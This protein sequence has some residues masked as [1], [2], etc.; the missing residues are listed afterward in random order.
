[1]VLKTVD[2]GTAAFRDIA[3]G[4]GDMFLLP[5][6]VP[7]NPVRFADTVGLVL[8]LP[9]PP[10]ALDRLRWY[11]QQCGAQVHEASFRCTDLGSQI[12]HAVERFRQ[13]AEA[14]RCARCGA[15]CDVVP[16]PSRAP[17]RS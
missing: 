1:M 11:C 4:E 8:E 17:D 14:R 3:I 6:G 10:G 5:A 13:D 16:G 2:P 7:H 12:K 9:R 15:R